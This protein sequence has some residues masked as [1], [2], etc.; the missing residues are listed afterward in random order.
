VGSL[1]ASAQVEWSGY[2][3]EVRGASGALT[4]ST[5]TQAEL[6]GPGA[7][8]NPEEL[9][10]AAHANCFTSTLTALAR[11]RELPIDR[12]RTAVVTELA[13]TDG[14]GDHRLASSTISVG[15]ASPAPVEKLEALVRDT[16]QDCPVCRA[17]AGNVAMRVELYRL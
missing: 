1:R 11:R 15:I 7:G 17:I 5:S 4:A 14:E 10:A 9:L 12:L 8:T 3:G 16:E 13:W 2:E 6:G